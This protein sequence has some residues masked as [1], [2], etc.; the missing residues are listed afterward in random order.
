[1]Q[2][3]EWSATLVSSSRK[4]VFRVQAIELGRT[5]ETVDRRSALAAGIGPANKRS[6]APERPHARHARR[7]CCRSP[8][9][10]RRRVASTR[11]QQ[12]L[13]IEVHR[14]RSKQPERIASE[15]LNGY[16]CRTGGTSAHRLK[17]RWVILRLKPRV[18]AGKAALRAPGC[19]SAKAR[20]AR[21]HWTS[22]SS[23]SVSECGDSYSRDGQ[24]AQTSKSRE[25]IKVIALKAPIRALRGLKGAQ[26][27]VET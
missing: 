12:L 18:A 9:H 17:A 14:N 22:A 10:R 21:F 27:T 3:T 4:Y 26:C 2:F 19:K 25:I 13:R 20:R 5:D 11:N 23:L 1:M 16:P 6:S 8:S 7:H 15:V 24:S